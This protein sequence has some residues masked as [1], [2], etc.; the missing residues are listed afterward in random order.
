MT[1]LAV[2]YRIKLLAFHARSK[3]DLA[4][5][6]GLVAYGSSDEEE[7]LDDDQRMQLKS[8]VRCN[9]KHE[10]WSATD[11]IDLKPTTIRIISI[12]KGKTTA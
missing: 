5:M 3:F 6:T 2:I 1:T 10:H 11:W 9:R 8:R 7:F 12:T 4:A